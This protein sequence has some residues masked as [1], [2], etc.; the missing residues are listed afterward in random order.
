LLGESVPVQALVPDNKNLG[1]TWTEMNFDDSSW[2]SGTTGVGYE[3]GSGYDPFFGLDLDSPPGGQTATPMF[4]ENDT[5]YI[6]VPFEITTDLSQYDSIR[7]RMMYDDGFVA[8]INGI[9]VARANAP[10]NLDYNSGAPTWHD[11]GAAMQFVDFDITEFR[12]E[13][14]QNSNVL[15][16]HGLNS[17]RTSSDFLIYP[18]IVGVLP[19]SP[20]CHVLDINRM[21]EVGNLAAGVVTSVSTERF[22]LI[23][24]DIID[25]ADITE[26][27]SQAA[28]ENGHSSPYLRGDTE[29]DRDVDITD[30]NSL[31]THFDPDGATA[32]HSWTEGNFDGDNDIDITDFN[33]L[34]AN[35][36]PDG[37]GASAVPEPSSLLLALLGLMLLVG[38]RVQ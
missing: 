23:D 25:A 14:V 26:W 2:L 5:V 12:N 28:T 6:R 34:A 17:A 24:N 10:P 22:D 9:E 8:Y 19:Q 7:L 16:I 35:F 30:F 27:L 37:Y 4:G 15:A 31:A 33:F 32:P 13:I 29:F 38:A 36:A 20:P 21:F 18:E 3:R 11:E 1:L